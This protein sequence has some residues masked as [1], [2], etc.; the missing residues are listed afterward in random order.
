MQRMFLHFRPHAQYWYYKMATFHSVCYSTTVSV[1]RPPGEIQRRGD[2]ESKAYICLKYNSLQAVVLET[3]K[4]WQFSNRF[5]QSASNYFTN[6]NQLSL[7]V[8]QIL[9]VLVCT[10]QW[11]QTCLSAGEV[12]IYHNHFCST[13]RQ[14][15]ALRNQVV[16]RWAK[17]RRDL[18]LLWFFSSPLHP[19]S[20][21]CSHSAPKLLL[22]AQIQQQIEDPRA[23]RTSLNLQ[24]YSEGHSWRLGHRC[25][26]S[27]NFI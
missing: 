5:H 22:V 23:D 17:S 27:S 13:D 15:E 9:Q 25:A 21:W 1:L 8:S 6:T 26:T 7:T 16:Q 12:N 14:T 11:G 3:A 18:F 10:H 19:H 20:F 2:H 4:I 24:N